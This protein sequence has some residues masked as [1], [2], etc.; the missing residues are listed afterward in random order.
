M[1]TCL[2]AALIAAPACALVLE[3]D[4]AQRRDGWQTLTGEWAWEDGKLAQRRES[5]NYFMAVREETV[6]EGVI[7]VTGVATAPNSSGDGC[8]GIVCKH[9]DADN[10]VVIRFGAY[11]RAWLMMTVDGERDIIALRP[12]IAEI[13]R[14][15]RCEVTMT[16]GLLMA[17]VDG[18]T[19]GVWRDPFP[20]R[21]GRPGVYAQ[22]PAEFS[23]FRV[24]EAP[25]MPD[26]TGPAR[27]AHAAGPRV[28]RESATWALEA[29]EYAV[30]P[31]SPTISGPDH[32]T[33]ALYLRNRS[34]APAQVTDV[35]LDGEPV[36]AL[37][38]AG[39]VAWWRVWPEAV[40]PGAVAQ[41]LVK[42]SGAT[43]T[44]AAQA[45]LG[46]PVGPHR[47]R[48]DGVEGEALEVE[49]ALDPQPPPLRI[50]FIAFDDALETL[51]VYLATEGGLVGRR[52]EQVEVN[53]EDVTA[54]VQPALGPLR[55]DTLP[56]RVDLARPLERAAATVVT[57]RAEGG[58]FA[59]HAVRAFPAR[60]PV[61]VVILGRQ[62][63]AEEVEEIANLCFTEVGFCGG[64][65]ENM[66]ELVR[67]GLLYFPYAYPRPGAI[68]AYLAQP[69]RPPLTAWWID[70][71]DRGQISPA[72][73]QRMLSE[74][75][76]LMRERGLPVAPHCM[77]IMAPWTDVGYIEL[78]DA[79][80]HEYGVD[81]GIRDTERYRRALD[82]L[83]PGDISRRELRTARRPWWPYFR[84]I[85][86]VLLVEP[87][88]KEVVGHYRPIDPREHRLI[89]YSC[90]ANGAKG[91]LNWNYGVNYFTPQQ[92]TWLSDKYDAIRLNM[93][94]L[95]EPEAFGVPI[96][97]ELMDGLQEATHECGRVNAELQLLGPL[98]ARGD[99]SDLATVTRSAPETNPRGGPAAHA[100]AI[101]CG[102]DAIVLFVIN[103][104]IDSNF[105]ARRPE[106]VRSYEPVSVD[107]DLALPPWL[108]PEDVFEVSWRGITPIEAAREGD[109]LGFSFP[110][111][112]VATAI[113]VTS[114]PGLRGRTEA[115]L[116]PLRERLEAAGVALE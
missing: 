13:G 44:Q 19:M 49:F 22:S 105:N 8:I 89:V 92:L 1:R 20:E 64:R 96:P 21:A 56:V 60:F 93:T 112:E 40:P 7:T 47:V 37:M 46:S 98:L 116:G 65:F 59:G 10:W 78:A 75:D 6:S 103:L 45:M 25:E 99:V 111:V 109:A 50:N 62:P 41:V 11:K 34:D 97:Q 23:L 73:A 63:G 80:S 12:F 55:A 113:V 71:I 53:G 30:A 18:K 5:D 70:E 101:I 100:R 91:A 76:A 61:Q 16:Q 68:E 31:L 84:N 36:A 86:A 88:T 69:E 83:T 82:F 115:A 38:E 52:I 85:E 27:A 9:I 110:G 24:G 77:N 79:L 114:D 14:E 57:V 66:A 39:R 58:A 67:H 4:F 28:V 33:L 32:H 3:D 87:E 2:L 104:D 35:A 43:L 26:V 29:V 72:E 48:L 15:Y 95:K 94:A 74:A 54:R 51:H 81:F 42:S 17:E 90:L 102:L 108:E 106:P 107:V